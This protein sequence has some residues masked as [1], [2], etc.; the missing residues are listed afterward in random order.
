MPKLTSPSNYVGTFH[1]WP[2]Q[3]SSR[4]SANFENL[5]GRTATVDKQRRTDDETRGLCCLVERG[6]SQLRGS[7]PQPIHWDFIDYL[8]GA[9]GAEQDFFARGSGGY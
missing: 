3:F 7:T 2:A 8:A 4:F 9:G 6:G 1:G 5:L